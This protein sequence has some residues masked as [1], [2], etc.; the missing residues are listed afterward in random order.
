[1]R[2]AMRVSKCP[3]SF[4]VSVADKGLRL[5]VDRRLCGDQFRLT[6]TARRA[7]AHLRRGTAGRARLR[8]PVGSPCKGAIHCDLSP[9][10]PRLP[11]ATSARRPGPAP[12]PTVSLSPLSATLTKSEGALFTFAIR[13][14]SLCRGCRGAACYTLRAQASGIVARDKRL[15]PTLRP[16]RELKSFISNAYRKRGGAH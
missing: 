7:A 13:Q 1:M 9:R 6:Q 16:H 11:S 12:T 8:R 3:P 5:A 14:V 4:S 2:G 15:A 10:L